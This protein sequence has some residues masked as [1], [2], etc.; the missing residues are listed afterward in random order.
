MY[1]DRL[2]HPASAP[3]LA[4]FVGHYNVALVVLSFLMA[5]LASFGALSLSGRIAASKNR[6]GH[7]AWVAAG[8]ASMGL[9]IWAMHFIG[10]LA[11]S[12]PCGISYDPL[13]TLLSIFPGMLASGVALEVVSRREQ[14]SLRN[15]I[16][17]AVLMGAGIG[18]MHYSGMAAVRLPGV[19]RYDVRLVALSVFVAVAFAF[20]SLSM[21]CVPQL[22]AGLKQ[23]S[24]LGSAIVMGCAI[25]NMHYTA[26]HA[27]LFFPDA[28]TADSAAAVD[29]TM[30]VALVTG[31]AVFT[32]AIVLAVG[33][34]GAQA[35]TAQALKEE[36]AQR[37]EVEQ[38]ALRGRARLQAIFDSVV[39]AILTVGPDETVRQWSPA[40]E[41][42]FGYTAVEAIGAHL[43][44]LVPEAQFFGFLGGQETMGRR[45]DGSTFPVELSIS[46]VIAGDELL[47]TV[48]IRDIS[49]RK[50]AEEQLIAARKQADS[51]NV[52]K[53][54]FLAN[55][56][57][58]IRTPMNAI[59]GM[60]HLVEKTDLAPRQRDF[61]RKIQHSSRHLLAIIND[62]LDF[63]KIEAGHLSLENAEFDLEDTLASV[64]DV[65]SERAMSKGL[66]VVFDVSQDVRT[67]VVGDSLRLG[68]I[69]INLVNNAVKFTEQGEI[70]ISVR[71]T[72][73]SQTAIELTLSVKDTGIGISAE[74]QAHLFQSFQ[75]ADLGITR[76]Y[77][78]TGLGLAISKR[79]AEL[80]QGTIDVESE[81]GKGSTFRVSVW[82]GKAAIRKRRPVLSASLREKRLLVVDDNG[83]ARSAIV[84]MLASNG[85]AVEAASNGASAIESVQKSIAAGKPYDVAFVDWRMPGIDGVETIRRIRAL[86]ATPPAFV[87]VTAYGREEVLRLADQAGLSEVLVKPVNRSVLFDATMRAL[88][89]ERAAFEPAFDGTENRAKLRGLKILVA[90]DNEMN[91][92][93]ARELL[94]AVG[95][96][97]DVVD[98]GAAA[99]ERLQDRSYDLV[100][101]DLRMPVMDGIEAT[102]A[103]RRDPLFAELPIIAMTAN[104]MASDR[105]ACLEAGMNDHIGK[106]V[107]PEELYA[108]LEVWADR[109]GKLSVGDFGGTAAPNRETSAT[110]PED[111]ALL[112]RLAPALD[113]RRGLERVL[114]RTE[115]YFTL[116]RSYVASQRDVGW[117]IREALA[118]G[119]I[120][121]ATRYAHSANGLAGQIGADAVRTAAEH[122]ESVL[123][124][125][126]PNDEILAA[127]SDL[128]D[129]AGTVVGAIDVVL[130]E[131]RQSQRP[132]ESGG[133]LTSEQLIA[134]GEIVRLLEDDDPKARTLW[135]AHSDALVGI[136]PDGTHVLVT[137]AVDNFDFGVA[138]DALS[139]TIELAKS[140]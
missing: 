113:V 112:Q 26:M 95:I 70:V 116:L 71:Q 20:I 32:I 126:G 30:L 41:R 29:P 92:E 98:D 102:R 55:M 8:A 66:E 79:L 53:S 57:H 73:E 48:I 138:R 38:E 136:I 27:A 135:H 90:E 37:L 13:Q 18:A 99:L 111:I 51:A 19:L 128:E 44:L 61:V 2:F 54:L 6:R 124:A 10:M 9:G 132:S 3:A 77:G 125:H 127:L 106:P 119:Q 45:K 12:L 105:Q 101:M 28:A 46:K 67:Q 137:G 131:R 1:L 39:D 47:F 94:A 84:R 78:G 117:R 107:E 22:R 69:L 34:A 121:D 134:L 16:L 23:Y 31:L 35:E 5:I 91:Q 59:I 36:V 109:I 15:L 110:S 60:T 82:L 122:L 7:F 118:A 56:S 58:E 52:A 75:Q 17:G 62:I 85:F 104:A 4:A 42:I 86:T 76:R 93:V 72:G 97:V 74:Q 120:D 68:Q 14:V 100:L 63:S 24:I 108:V 83:N 129:T 139:R 25:A 114:D 64:G 21:R 50:L 123:R 140:H 133:F 65:V 88:D 96:A 80:M 81:P 87:L 89:E 103:I 43:T 115:L 33:F 40:A 130:P 11:F 49:E